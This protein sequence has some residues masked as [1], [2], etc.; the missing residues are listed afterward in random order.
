LCWRC[1]GNDNDNEDNPATPAAA[2]DWAMYGADQTRS[3]HNGGATRLGVDTAGAIVPR[4]QAD[5]GMGVLPPSGTPAVAAGRVFVGSSV[6]D[7]NNFFAFDATTG[8]PLWSA[9]IGH[10]GANADGISIGASP[11][12][13]GSVVVAGGGDQAYYG[14]RAETGEVIWRNFM[15]VGASGFP[16]CSPLVAAGRAYVGMASEFDNPSVRGEVRALDLA[17]GGVLARQ[18]FVP[19]GLGGAGVWNSPALSPDGRTLVVVTGEDFAGYDGPYN[20][21]IVSLDSVTLEIGQV[22]KQGVPNNDEDWGTT[23]VVFHDR[24]GRVLVGAH[25][26]NNVFYAYALEGIAAGPIWQRD[27][28]LTA[29]CM[30]AYDPN[31]GDGGTLFIA[32]R[33][34]LVLAVDPATGADRWAPVTVQTGHG[35]LAVANGLLF[36]PSA[37]GEVFVLE[38][39]TGRILRQLTPTNGGP[40]YSGVALAGDLI[41]WLSGSTLQAWGIP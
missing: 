27:T 1:H 18:F 2:A 30:S 41:Y 24:T 17:T 20:R 37:G 6:A 8:R 12:V 36:F 22:N 28:G 23:P 16:W 26:K 32:G 11:A 9:N 25:H 7:G 19:E 14:L 15:D 35:N 29:G 3:G 40:T 5:I 38:S 13:S 33:S 4:W 21:A 31:V 34:G 39:A 10:S